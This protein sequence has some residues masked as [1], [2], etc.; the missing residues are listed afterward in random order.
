MPHTPTYC[1][2]YNCVATLICFSNVLLYIVQSN[3]LTSKQGQTY[4]FKYME[5]KQI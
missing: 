3:I 2:C 5:K 1:N 4:I